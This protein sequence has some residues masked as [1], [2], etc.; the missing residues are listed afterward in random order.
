MDSRASQD[1]TLAAPARVVPSVRAAVAR[2]GAGRAGV[3]VPAGLLGLVLTP[4]V[5]RL[6][7]GAPLAIPWGAVALAT[8]LVLAA[9]RTG[10][11]RHRVARVVLLSLAVCGLGSLWLLATGR[12]P[13]RPFGDGAVL[14]Q[15]V[16]DGRAMPR[17]LLGSAV[18][19]TAHALVWQAPPVAAA[20]P[21]A[22][23]HASAFVA[24]ACVAVMLGGTW[25]LCRR[26]P[27]Q[28][29]VLLPLLTPVW[30]LFASG[31][32]EYYPLIAPAFVATLAWIFDRP[33]EQR[34]ANTIGI[35]CGV[36][37]V[38]YLGFAPV[39]VLL[40]LAWAVTRRREVGSGLLV[41]VVVAWLV[42]AACWPEGPASFART[43]HG[44]INL[45]EAHL[46]PRFAGHVASPTSPMFDAGYVWSTTRLREVAY[47]L[48]WGGGWWTWPLLIVAAAG[49]VR[50]QDGMWRDGRVWLGAGLVGWHL[51]YLLF[52]VPRLGV[53][54]DID[55]YFSVYLLAPFL[56]GRLFDVSEAGRD[57]RVVAGVLALASLGV[58]CTAPALVWYGL[59]PVP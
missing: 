42:V 17:W 15:F 50:R 44:V 43:L 31:Y 19:G 14:A 32:V 45:G 53:T 21:E 3:V 47:A 29:A 48:A 18:A 26:W 28:L 7:S 46:H 59:P 6:A 36:L 24:L 13:V 1:L 4:V 11:P 52:M 12:L 22:L 55:L 34:P 25:T 35:V 54:E 51:Y 23:R 39:A 5:L 30:F 38:L 33:L 9:V 27:G 10:D 58:A 20:L 49:A 41:S 2:L 57:P 40:W 8:V 56:A 16:A 37:P